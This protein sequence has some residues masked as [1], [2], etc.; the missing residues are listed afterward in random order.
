[1]NVRIESPAPC[2]RE[3][4]I[5]VP[6]E[7]VRAVF[8]EVASLYAAHVP[9][10]GFRPGRAPKDIVRMR[11]RKDIAG[12]VKDRLIPEAY[13]AALKKEK[14]TA[15]AVLDVQDQEIDESRPFV[16]SVTI[17]VAPDFALPSYKGIPLQRRAQT[18]SDAD[19]DAVLMELRIKEAS[20]ADV[21]GRPVQPDDLV[22]VDFEGVCEGRPI[23]ELAPDAEELGPA[24]NFWMFATEQHE[25]LPGFARG[26]VGASAG[27]RREILVDFPADYPQSSL[28]GRKASYFVTVKAI[29]EP[30]LPE[31][32]AD[33]CKA[34]GM[35]T[36]EDFRRRVREDLLRLREL[37]ED[38]RLKNEIIR[39]LLD[40][41][42][43]ELPESILHEETRHAVYDLVQNSQ[44]HGATA[45]DINAHKEGLVESATRTAADKVKLKFILRRIAEEERID[46]EERDVED[47][48]RYLANVWNM[49]AN[50]LRAEL[51]QRKE[52]DRVREEVL[53]AKVL[54]YLLEKAVITPS[55][56][57]A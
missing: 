5:E 52:M 9:I 49:P 16:F 41:A 34:H 35:A 47:R 17:D 1:M 30:R 50:R 29:R 20:Y 23:R 55:G 44:R 57:A 26:L 4:H 42:S 15:V 19:V 56:A 14:L 53:R 10:P 37:N 40:S 18:V 38:R 21:A 31:L 33:F 13:Q 51:E 12:D 54:A 6:V 36:P 48:I 2:R 32:D 11:Y 28:A 46:V 43:F 22:Q 7:R 25:F 8:D 39:H 3:I 24:R 45:E 27:E